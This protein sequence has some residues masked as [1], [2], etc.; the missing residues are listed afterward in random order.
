MFRMAALFVVE[1]LKPWLMTYLA[2]LLA[3]A[4]PAPLLRQLST[5]WVPPFARAF[6]IPLCQRPESVAFGAHNAARNAF[7][8]RNAALMMT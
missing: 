6:N 1:R 3:T 4:A 7:G 8:A 2:A 5:K